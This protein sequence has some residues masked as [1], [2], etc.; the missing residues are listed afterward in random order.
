MLHVS[1]YYEYKEYMA[2]I[3]LIRTSKYSG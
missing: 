3:P 1:K 2:V